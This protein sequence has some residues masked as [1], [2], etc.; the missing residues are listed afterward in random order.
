MRLM[1]NW[2][3][4]LATTPFDL[5]Q[6]YLFHLVANTSSFTKAAQKAGTTQ[7]AI[8]RQIR[9]ME[10]ALGVPHFERTTRHVALTTA[11]RLLLDKSATI[12]DATGDLLKQLQQDFNLVP[13]TLRIGVA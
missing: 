9:G 12:L 3:A 13:K 7:S 2:N 1:L 10:T 8:T 11:G 5:Y 6:L 4:Y